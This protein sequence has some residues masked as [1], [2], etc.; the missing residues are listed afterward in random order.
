VESQYVNAD[1]S[2]LLPKSRTLEKLPSTGAKVS[3]SLFRRMTNSRQLDV[4]G[5]GRVNDRTLGHER[6]ED[7]EQSKVHVG[8]LASNQ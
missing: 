7:L 2:M 1:E 6:Q 5:V 8:A 4:R 3:S